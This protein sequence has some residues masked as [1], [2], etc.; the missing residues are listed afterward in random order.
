MR[1]HVK[2]LA[3]EDG[4]YLATEVLL[5]NE[6]VGGMR[7]VSGTVS[8]IDSGARSFVVDA[9]GTSITVTTDGQTDYKKRGGT[10]SFSDVTA[11]AAVEV[12]GI[13]QSDGS[14]LARKVRLES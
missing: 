2:A 11:G 14:V 1:V 5:Q 7:E 12:K 8:S 6:Q 4:S 10:A 9:G 3:Q 13:L